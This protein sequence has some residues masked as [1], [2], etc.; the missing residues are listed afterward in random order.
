MFKNKPPIIIVMMCFIQHTFC[1][2][3][4]FITPLFLNIKFLT[5]TLVFVLCFMR[6]SIGLYK[7]WLIEPEL[8]FVLSLVLRWL[9]HV[10]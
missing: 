2:M 7:I 10:K 8:G 1:F 6:K 4:F 3:F 5:F 9:V